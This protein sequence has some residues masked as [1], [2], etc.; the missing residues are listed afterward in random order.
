MI[1]KNVFLLGVITMILNIFG[2]SPDM[3]FQKY[4][5]KDAELGLE[6]DCFYGWSYNEDRGANGSYAQVLFLEPS[7]KNKPLRACLDLTVTR[8]SKATFTPLTLEG[9]YNDLIKK[10]QTLK[11]VK[12]LSHA[13]YKVCREPALMVDMTYSVLKN[14]ESARPDLINMFE[15][16]ILWK[17]GDRFYIL[18]Y[19]DVADMS[20]LRQKAF[21]R[22]VRTIKLK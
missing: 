7:E 20:S 10:R 5:S 21:M 17:K 11:G 15:R 3:A 6:M 8:E 18:R 9:F 2:C 16:A 12:I 14:P 19:V 1:M 13:D 4:S 22:C